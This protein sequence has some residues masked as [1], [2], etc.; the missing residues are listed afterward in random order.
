MATSRRVA[1]TTLGCKVNQYDSEA[2]M[3]LFRRSGYRIVPFDETADVYVVNTCTVTG[4]GAAKSRQLIRNAVRRSPL[5]VVAVAGCYTQ[6]DPDAVAAIPGVSLIIG[7]QDR[8]RVVELCEQAARAPEPIR[9]VNNIWQAREFEELPVDS[10]TGHTR[11]VVKIQ[12][13]C[14]IF[15]TFCIIPYARGKPRSRRPE[16]VVQEVERLANDGFR[17]VVL[18]GIHLGSYGKDCHG[19]FTL[20]QVVEQLTHMEGIDRIRLSSLEPKHVSPHLMDLLEHNPKVCRHLHLSLQSGSQTVLERMKRAYTAREYRAVVEELHRRIPDL[21]LST[22]VI[23]GFP[24]ETEAEHRES[25]AFAREMGFNRLHVFPFSPRKGTPAAEMPGQVSKAVKERRTHEMIGLG[26]ELALAFANRFQGQTLQVLTEEEA[27]T[28]HGW[29]EGYT[30]NYI[31]VRFPGG[32]ELKNCIVP[33]TITAVE[34]DVCTGD[35]AGY[36]VGPS[37]R[38]RR[39][40]GELPLQP[41]VLARD[42]E[43]LPDMPTGEDESA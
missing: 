8:D 18:T 6:T 41:V 29:L 16:S 5:S 3:A 11:A 27:D 32:D 19:E 24:D 12:E 40:A 7:N 31:R 9:A 28:E 10:F 13:G 35:M 20:A 38:I 15:C 33:V 37:R 42:L 21:G 2:M 25:M 14:N 39:P 1:F 26:R 22:D 30:D 43:I 4:R 34:E 23:I 36:P 17:E